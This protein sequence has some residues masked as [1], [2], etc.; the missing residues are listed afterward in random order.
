VILLL[1]GFAALLSFPALRQAV[2]GFITGV[3]FFVLMTLAL[4]PAGALI[5]R[6][7]GLVAMVR[8]FWRPA[9]PR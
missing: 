1:V 7:L 4:G 6:A 9:P 5:A 8:G 3:A 2:G